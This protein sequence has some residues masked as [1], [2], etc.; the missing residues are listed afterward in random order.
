MELTVGRELVA[1]DSVD[2]FEGCLGTDIVGLLDRLE[3]GVVRLGPT[4]EAKMLLS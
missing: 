1:V 2:W 3:A 4:M